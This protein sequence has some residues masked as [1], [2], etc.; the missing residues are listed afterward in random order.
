M[1][2]QSLEAA[3]AG[4][5]IHREDTIVNVC[6]RLFPLRNNDIS[7]VGLPDTKLRGWLRSLATRSA[8]TSAIVLR[9][10]PSR[11]CELL[12][13]ENWTDIHFKAVICTGEPLFEH[14]ISLIQNTLHCPVIN[15]YG[16]QECG[17]QLWSCPQCHQFHPDT[18]RCW[19]EVINQEL[20]VTDLYSD[21]M[22]LLR[23]RNGDRAVLVASRC[24]RGNLALIP[25][26]RE[27]EQIQTPECLPAI[28]ALSYYRILDQSP[29]GLTLLY[30]P[31]SPASVLPTHLPGHIP[32]PVKQWI[33]A[34]N[35]VE[36]WN[37]IHPLPLEPAELEKLPEIGDNLAFASHIATCLESGRWIFYRLPAFMRLAQQQF[38]ERQDF[39]DGLEA[40]EI[41][42]CLLRLL[43]FEPPAAKPLQRWL[44]LIEERRTQ[45]TTSAKLRIEFLALK[46]LYL[47]Q[48][49]MQCDE[50]APLDQAAYRS[51]IA[52]LD[53]VI[54]ETRQD[55]PTLPILALSPLL[56][57]FLADLSH[58]KDLI[59]LLAHWAILLG[60]S[61][62]RGQ[63]SPDL[64]L[65]LWQ[66]EQGLRHPIPLV[67]PT[68]TTELVEAC[69]QATLNSE[70]EQLIEFWLQLQNQASISFPAPIAACHLAA[71]A[72]G[73]AAA[74]LQQGDRERSYHALLSGMISLPQ[75]E[76]FEHHSTLSNRK[77]RLW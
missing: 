34:A 76:C 71:F 7:L 35:G 69:V 18:T 25:L 38:A 50:V 51:L 39:Q 27:G 21:L 29:G 6:S 42:H 75:H 8:T 37:R 57:L 44:A 64:P 62:N 26:G 36:F 9:G 45:F 13:Q 4:W 56:A 43:C 3:L 72:R 12:I 60:R 20:V 54:R 53:H 47:G 11:V 33:P 41:D 77:Q 55:Q 59:T 63:H 28:P 14:Q 15:E 30:L 49:N 19:L 70:P 24:P 74:Y 2:L 1:R 65:Q 16:S 23:Y 67:C 61:Q 17:L 68:E 5:Q 32:Q 46:M 58:Y 31:K 73:V 66:R 48:P 22:P 10:F 40:K 52:L